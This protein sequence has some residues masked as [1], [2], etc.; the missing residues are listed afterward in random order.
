MLHAG[1]VVPG[2]LK[3]KVSWLPTQIWI[4]CGVVVFVVA[5]TSGCAFVV[6]RK[7]PLEPFHADVIALPVSAHALPE[8]N[9]EGVS[10][11]RFPLPSVCRI[12]APTV[13]VGVRLAGSVR[14]C[15]DVAAGSGCRITPPPELFVR[16]NWLAPKPCA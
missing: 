4:G 7:L 10:H 6:P 9:A 3:R 11:D 14:G 1:A 16:I 2:G 15:S 5:I 13:L 12:P 8:T